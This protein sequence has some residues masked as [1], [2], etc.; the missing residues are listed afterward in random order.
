MK[1]TKASNRR[2]FNGLVALA[3]GGVLAGV[4]IGC[5]TNGDGDDHDGGEGSCSGEGGWGGEGGCN[6]DGGS[7]SGSAS[8]LPHNASRT[9]RRLGRAGSCR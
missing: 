6:A 5:K 8:W 4:T 7:G 1:N 2:H 9:K 3:I